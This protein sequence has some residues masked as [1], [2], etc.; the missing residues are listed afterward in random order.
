MTSLRV[1]VMWRFGVCV[2]IVLSLLVMNLVGVYLF[3]TPQ[4]PDA[5]IQT[6][7]VLGSQDGI[8][9]ALSIMF[10]A[11]VLS[12]MCWGIIYQKTRSI[13]QTKDFFNLGKF[14]IKDLGR[15]V[16]IMIIIVA[17]SELLMIYFDSTPMTFL[18]DIMTSGSFWWLI[19]AIVV[20]APIYE[21]VVFR[22]LIFGIIHQDGTPTKSIII[23]SLLFAV[24][25]LQYDVI[26]MMS[27]FMLGVLFCHARL[28]HGLGL[29]M[30]LHFLNNAVAMVS[31]FLLS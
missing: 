4:M 3:A 12:L 25:H 7:L 29:A 22:G 30:L 11:G 28:K 27:I 10:T 1:S 15:Y 8:I 24:V 16:G 2:F 23:S 14:N 13:A 21:E 5:D 9:T 17:I 31:Y 19:I 20:I 18:D 26:G 6:R